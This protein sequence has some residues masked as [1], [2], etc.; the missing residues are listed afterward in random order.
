MLMTRVSKSTIRAAK[1]SCQVTMNQLKNSRYY[2]NRLFSRKHLWYTSILGIWSHSPFRFARFHVLV[3]F[4][5]VEY[6]KS[7]VFPSV[8]RL[9]TLSLHFYTFRMSI[10]ILVL[11]F[12]KEIFMLLI[13]FCVFTLSLLVLEFV[14]YMSPITSCS[15]WWTYLRF[16]FSPVWH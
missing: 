3:Y 8:S 13:Y 9:T 2:P 10:L 11:I 7:R 6:D 16:Y 14:S 4:S 1:R 5:I 15:R 12:N